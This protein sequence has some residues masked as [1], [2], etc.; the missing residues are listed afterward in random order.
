MTA[1]KG[2][3]LPHQQLKKRRFSCSIWPKDRDTLM[4]GEGQ[5]EVIKNTVV[6]TADGGMGDIDE[7]RIGCVFQRHSVGY[8]MLFRRV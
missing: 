2:I 3:D 8:L 5:A 1:P 6:P 7:R 4:L